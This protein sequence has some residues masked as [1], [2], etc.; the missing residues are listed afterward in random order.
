MNFKEIFARKNEKNKEDE[1]LEQKTG[2]CKETE[3]RKETENGN[4]KCMQMKKGK[5]VTI[6]RDRTMDM[7]RQHAVIRVSTRY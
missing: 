4:D 6:T 5:K 7:Y 3:N 2:T 1:T